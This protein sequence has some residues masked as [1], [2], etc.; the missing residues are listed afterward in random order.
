MS[1]ILEMAPSTNGTAHAADKKI[2]YCT[3][4][5][6]VGWL[7][8]ALGF[9]DAAK[10]ALA[11]ELNIDKR[12][13]R[14]SYAILGASR[15]PLI[16]QGSALK[17]LLVTIRNQYTIP[18][19][20][21]MATA[22]EESDL[23][24]EK[25]AGS[26]LI[27]SV[28]I[29]EFLTR[30][31]EV[32]EQYLS[33][34]KQ[35]AEPANYQRLRDADEAALGKDWEVIAPRYPTAAQLA[36]AVTCDVPRI[37]PFDASF[38]LADVAPATAKL[39]REQAEARLAASVDGAV[40]ELVL[41]FKGMV[42]AVARNCGKRIRLL[43]PVGH[44]RQD[45]RY[46][47]V[48]TILRHGDDPDAIPDGKL[49]VTVQ[50][51]SP[52]D[53][54]HSKYIQTGKAEDLLL[55]QAEYN[56]LN[57]YETDENKILAQSSFDNLLYLANKIQTVK[58]MLGTDSGADNLTKLAE[59]VSAT[60]G[61]LGG[62]AAEI[63]RQLKNSSFARAQAKATF[64]GFLDQLTTQEIEIRAAVKGPRR[65]IKLGGGAAD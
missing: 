20:T 33:W 23:K 9:T 50:R 58:S 60:L 24:A 61:S 19:Y 44:A 57:P 16:Q 11:A 42:E 3:V 22:N 45:L 13:I 52:R 21:L 43:P 48:Q 51:C 30:F 5:F 34:G 54:D 10:A 40:G 31:N 65:K 32:R 36:D 63:T 46:A 27:E 4:K 1:T 62:S 17:R 8:G 56:A 29:E 53:D 47:E 2:T 6:Q 12:V 35:V 28:K 14:G 64:Q 39:L 38:T 7:P 49:L 15:D 25:V 55:S 59:E 26:Y 37:E 41:E 18:E